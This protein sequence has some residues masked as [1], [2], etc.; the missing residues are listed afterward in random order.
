M[1]QDGYNAMK[2]MIRNERIKCPHSERVI[3]QMQNFTDKLKPQD[4]IVSDDI[5]DTIAMPCYYMNNQEDDKIEAIN[6]NDYIQ[7]NNNHN[8]GFRRY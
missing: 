5:L 1:K 4:I 7:N 2:S 6:P 3:E 8:Y